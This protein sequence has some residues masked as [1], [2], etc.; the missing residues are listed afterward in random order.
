MDPKLRVVVHVDIDRESAQIE[1]RG[2]VTT[3]N[4]VALYSLVRRTSALASGLG[5]IINLQHARIEAA[6]LEELHDCSASE[7]LPGYVAHEGEGCRLRVIDPPGT[8]AA[9]LAMAGSA[10]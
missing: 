2:H 10:G 4:I 9:A 7:H 1:V 3:R 8:G 6:A 5:V